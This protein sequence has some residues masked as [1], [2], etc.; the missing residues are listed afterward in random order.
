ME[1]YTNYVFYQISET[2]PNMRS[3]PLTIELLQGNDML[4][5]EEAQI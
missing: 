4:S 3:S 5:L 2:K 1:K